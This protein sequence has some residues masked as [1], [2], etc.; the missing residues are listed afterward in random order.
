[1]GDISTWSPVDAN[2]NQNPPDG[3]PEGQAPSTVNNC[4]RADK[5]AI[6]RW[7]EEGEW[8]NYGFR[9]SRESATKFSVSS[10]TST[11]VAWYSLG[12]RIRFRESSSGVEGYGYVASASV[13]GATTN[14]TCVFDS[15]AS[16]TSSLSAVDVGI[17]DTTGYVDGFTSSTIPSG[18]AV[19]LTTLTPA[20]ITSISLPAGEWEVWG[21]VRVTGTATTAGGI[22]GAI[23]T[24]SATL[25]NPVVGA[26]SN[27]DTGTGSFSGTGE[28]QLTVGTAKLTLTTTTTVY[29]IGYA[30]FSG[31]TATAYGVICARRRS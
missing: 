23:N 30:S 3:W 25:P 13:S 11:A 28:R 9:V 16:L 8:I 18:S 21:E 4:A 7:Y 10:A 19:S 27:R 15:S 1:M 12:R 6:R 2:N 20:N 24:T 31:G 5:G 29:L 22:I 14:V 26:R 17:M